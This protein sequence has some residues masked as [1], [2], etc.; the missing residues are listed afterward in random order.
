MRLA[1][2][3]FARG[4]WP[5]L[6]FCGFLFLKAQLYL[7]RPRNIL[8]LLYCPRVITSVDKCWIPDVDRKRDRERYR[9]RTA[10]RHWPFHW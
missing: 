4:G 2:F 6:L 3:N 10:T 1:F 5:S 7:T 9:D 8:R